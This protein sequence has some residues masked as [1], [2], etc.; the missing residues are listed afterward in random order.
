MVK[1]VQTISCFECMESIALVKGETLT[2]IACANCRQAREDTPEQQTRYC[3][4][5][6]WKSVLRALVGVRDTWDRRQQPRN[7]QR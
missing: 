3:N 1:V 7:R 4:D 5:S 2:R 6:P